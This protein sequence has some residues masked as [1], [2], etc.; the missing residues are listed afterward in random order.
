MNTRSRPE[1]ISILGIGISSITY[2]E[3]VDLV[4]SCAW[5]KKP[6]IVSALAVHG[7]VTGMLNRDFGARLNR[8][9]VLAPDGQ[10]VRWALNWLGKCGLKERVYGPT[11]MLKICERAQQEHM[12]IYCFGSTG[13]VV[14]ALAHNLKTK[15]PRLIISGYQ[16]DR[17]GEASPEED[18]DDVKRISDS[19]AR[20]VFCGRG[21]PR[22]EVW[23]YNHRDRINGPLVAVGA[24]FDFHAGLL[25]QAP[26]VLQKAGLE[27]VF[28]L[29][30]EPRRLWKRYMLLNPLF[31][32]AI[33]LQASGIYTFKNQEERS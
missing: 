24:A 15:Y 27:W 7:L 4:S 1:K 22:Q 29:A 28:R 26:P 20:I 30:H 13:K 16:A 2:A 33:L 12:G 9:D 21:C 17:F 11:L 23:C 14:E 19:G 10:P 5:E 6:L 3:T 25:P 18:A 32:I 8:F 31:I